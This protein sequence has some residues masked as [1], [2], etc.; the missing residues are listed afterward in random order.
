MLIEDIG[1]IIKHEHIDTLQWLKTMIDPKLLRQDPEAVFLAAKR[2]GVE[3]DIQ[4]YQTLEDQR[5]VLQ[6]KTQSLQA[7]RNQNAKSV[8]IAKSKG[9]DVAVLLA[10]VENLSAELKKHETELEIIQQQ[11]LDF[12]YLIPNI[13]L[14]SVPDGKSEADNLEI[15]KWGDIKKFDFTPKDHV[16][17]GA[18]D[19]LM[20]FEAA[21][22]MSG[23][24]FVVLKAGLA[25]LQRAL[26][27]FMLDLHINQHGYTEVYVPYLVHPNAMVGSGQL[28]K[29]SADSFAITGEQD[30]RLIPTAEVSMVNI[31][32]DQIIDAKQLPLKFVAHSPC[33]RSEAG[34]Y[35]KDTR[36][37]IRQHQFQKVELVQIAKPEDSEKI[38]E[39]MVLHAEKV[40]QLLNLPY[41]VVLLCSA[42]TGFTAAKTYDLEVWL[43][44]QNTYREISSCSNCM[45]FQA[46]RLKTRFKASDKPEL[47]HTLNASGLAVGRTLVA[48]LENY[49][50]K[51]GKIHIPE[52]LWP[53]MNGIAVI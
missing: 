20:D 50:D 6:D 43:P 27:E 1:S 15:R 48:I 33:F 11:L 18:R 42:D 23:A 5:K 37:M 36:G 12:Q 38:H 19:D 3:I 45:D 16:E 24:R 51:D 40:L 35:G 2:H 17:L 29:F 47:V 39:E 8:G 4:H 41:R 44:S 13:L 7:Q 9:E 10:E 31:V 26:A 25:K 46:R 28:P 14:A 21:S 49:Q 30:F 34:S 52:V 32:R 22:N 53:Y